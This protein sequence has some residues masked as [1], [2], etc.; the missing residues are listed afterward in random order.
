MKSKIAKFL[1]S[2][3]K[4]ANLLTEQR[5]AEASYE[6]LNLLLNKSISQ[7]KPKSSMKNDKIKHY[8]KKG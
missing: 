2:K 4:I 1:N 5:K 8:F 7:K 3:Q 6:E